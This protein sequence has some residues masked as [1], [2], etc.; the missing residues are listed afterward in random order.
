MELLYTFCFL[1]MLF[2]ASD[3]L[4]VYYPDDYPV[5]GGYGKVKPANEKIQKI[6]NEVYDDVSKE[7][8]MSRGM[9]K[10]VEYK[11]AVAAG[12]NYRIKLDLG[13]NFYITIEVHKHWSGKKAEFLG[14]VPEIAIDDWNLDV[15]PGGYGRE[16]NAEEKHQKAVEMFKLDVERKLSRGRKIVLNRMYTAKT[17]QTQFVSNGE[18]C[19]IKVQI[20]GNAYIMVIIHKDLNGNKKFVDISYN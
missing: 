14:I 17:Y 5:M 19:K 11:E 9:Y 3:C 12:A 13:N 1:S 2:A 20:D 10:A 6:A 7:Y 18:N 15:L 16:Y 8:R 4:S